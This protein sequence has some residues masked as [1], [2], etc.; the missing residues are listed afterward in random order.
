[1]NHNPDIVR[2][3]RRLQ[4]AD[5]AD[6]SAT[7]GPNENLSPEEFEEVRIL[8]MRI[9]L[10]IKRG[11]RDA[12]YELVECALAAMRPKSESPILSMHLAEVGIDVR[13]CNTMEERHSIHTVQQLLEA[14]RHK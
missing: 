5:G 9:G 12:A 14:D 2:G 13:S 8:G 6:G 7:S 1:M 11:N 10:A 4:E 3:D